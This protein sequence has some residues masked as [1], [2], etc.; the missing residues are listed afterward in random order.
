M[1]SV[2]ATH[3]ACACLQA[4]NG[5]PEMSQIENIVSKH[6][7]IRDF[8]ATIHSPSGDININSSYEVYGMSSRLFIYRTRRCALG[9]GCP[10]GIQPA[11]QP[12]WRQQWPGTLRQVL[13]LL[14][15]DVVTLLHSVVPSQDVLNEDQP[16][17]PHNLVSR[18]FYLHEKVAAATDV[19]VL[20]ES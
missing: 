16:H 7:P 5:V 20:S 10:G 4:L 18:P 6:L 9:T 14:L 1:S 8:S 19:L 17:R 13:P 2:Y 11:L 12:S 15:A 3:L